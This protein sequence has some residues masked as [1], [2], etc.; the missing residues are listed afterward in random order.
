MLNLQLVQR[1]YHSNGHAA[2]F[3]VAIV[4]DPEENDTKLVI[5]FEDDDYIAVLSLDQLIDEEE[6]GQDN[7][8]RGDRYEALLRDHL[9]DEETR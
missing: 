1:A 4:D 3:V 8:W 9:W 5:M 2:P 6:I 7:S